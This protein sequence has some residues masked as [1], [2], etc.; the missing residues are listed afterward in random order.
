MLHNGS[1]NFLSRSSFRVPNEIK[2]AKNRTRKKRYTNIAIA[3]AITLTTW[4]P[5]KPII[6]NIIIFEMANNTCNVF[7]E[8]NQSKK[9]TIITKL[10]PLISFLNLINKVAFRK[11]K[12][13]IKI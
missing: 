5:I 13:S 8:N 3:I 9:Y 11:M 12:V 2:K 4:L 1:H 10:F 7:L 6:I